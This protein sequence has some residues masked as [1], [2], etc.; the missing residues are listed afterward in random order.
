MRRRLVV[1][2]IDPIGVEEIGGYP[3][4][5]VVSPD[6][7]LIGAPGGVIPL[8][9]IIEVEPYLVAYTVVGQV[10]GG[11][12]AVTGGHRGGM[13]LVQRRTAVA[14]PGEARVDKSPCP[15]IRVTGKEI[16]AVEPGESVDGS[17]VGCRIGRFE[18]F[19]EGVIKGN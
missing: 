16:A 18:P 10:K 11:D 19:G 8:V 9:A 17:S 2:D 4:G 12:Q 5:L 15:A 1:A 14:R 7:D 3:G 13:C 6:P